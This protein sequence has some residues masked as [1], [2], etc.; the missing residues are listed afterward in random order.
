MAAPGRELLI[1]VNSDRTFGPL[2]VFGFGGVDTDLV[3]DR[4]CR[5]VPITDID[6]EEMVRS[7][8]CSHLL[9]DNGA[10]DLDAV[11]DVLLRVGR[12]AELLPE[13]TELDANPVIT[14]ERG[15]LI[16]DARILLRPA[17]HDDPLL[18]ALHN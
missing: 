6:A 9:F 4:N 11:H 13:V 18:R 10:L 8:R 5:L 3:A 17:S 7:L 12:L 2:V 15:C 14:S 16:V 1:G